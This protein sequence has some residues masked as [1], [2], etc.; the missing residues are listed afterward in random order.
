LDSFKML[1]AEVWL[2]VNLVKAI[3]AVF[4]VMVVLASSLTVLQQPICQAYSSNDDW[5]MFHHDSTLAGFTTGSAPKSMPKVAW[6]TG[7]DPKAEF[8]GDPLPVIVDD[9]VYVSD[10]NLYAFNASNGK[11]IW[12]LKN[13]G[14][15][16]ADNGILYSARGAL[17]AS[18]GTS[19]WNSS[20]GYFSTVA[21]GYYYTSQEEQQ[22]NGNDNWLFVALNASTGTEIWTAPGLYLR[23]PPAVEGGYFY[24]GTGTGVSALN[25]YTGS[26]LWDCGINNHGVEVSPAVAEGRVYVS[27]VDGNVYCIDALTGE[28]IWN[29][30]VG[31][32]SYSSPAS[33]YGDV[34]IGSHD[35]KVYA[36]NAST[37]E[38]I[39]VFTNH[40]YNY[41]IES[42]PAVA[43]GAVYVVAGDGNLYA[44]D[45]FS[46]ATLWSYQVG[47]QPQTGCSPAIA[48]GRIY[49]G[50]ANTLL[51]VLETAQ[52]VDKL[53]AVVP[54][55]VLVL[56]IVIVGLLIYKKIKHKT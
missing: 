28:K 14:I 2:R 26:K 45:A 24:F 4:L 53:V 35:G 40:N 20:G 6:T 36:F 31:P 9:V 41:S 29:Y 19:I 10:G 23:Y 30:T 13:Q 52:P 12:E 5:P 37:G 8:M 44:L 25:A 16:V 43:N 17:N 3:F 56:A 48:D 51:T 18:T 32:G 55:T 15:S 21:D 47:V 50:S 34:Y 22:S 38:K 1:K 54:I 46:G 39:W 27:A 7:Y 49:V 11:T 42:S 33:A